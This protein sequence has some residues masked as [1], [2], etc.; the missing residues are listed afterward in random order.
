[1]T[2]EAGADYAGLD[3]SREAREQVVAAL[4]AS[5]GSIRHSEPYTHTVP[6]QPPLGRAHRAADLAAVVHGAWTSWPRPAIEAVERR[7]RAHPPRV[8]VAPLP[9]VAG[10]HP[11]VVH[12]APAVV[13]PPDPGLV[14]RRR[15]DLR[16]HRAARGRGLGARPR[17]ARHVVH[18]GAV[19]VRD[20]RLARGDA[21]AA[22]LLPDRRA[23]DGARHPLPVGRAHGDDGPRVHRRRPVRRRLRALGHP[24]ARRPADEQVAGHRH[25]PARRDRRATAPTRCASACWRCP[26]PRTCAT[27]PRR[28][29]R[30]RRWPT[31]SSTPRATCCCNVGAVDR[32]GAA[33]AR[34]SR[35]AGSSAACRRPRR[36]S[37]RN[38]DAF[39]FAKAA[40]GLYDFVYGELCDWYLEFI[41][42]REFDDD[43]SA[44][45]LHVLRETLAARPPGHPVRHRGAVVARARR[46]GPA[47]PA[48]QATRARRRR[49][50]T[51]TPRRAS[52]PSSPRSPRCAPGATRPASSPARCSRRAWTAST[53][54]PTLVARMAR[55]DLDG[56]RRADRRPCPFAGGMVEIRA[57]DARRPRRGGAQAR[58]RARAPAAARSRAPRP[59]SPTRAS[60]PRRREQ[61]VA[62]ERDKLERLRR[63]LEAL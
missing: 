24:G 8:A 49:C 56:R 10:E 13:G 35:T 5:R 52:A 48:Q 50:A 26:R 34:R 61:L 58:G 44:T 17:R 21:R 37:T 30:A 59:S 28:S 54:T 3:A 31:S 18:L 43:L 23:L 19:A 32:A 40:L 25:R 45:M 60:W 53:A 29:A 46:R 16:R 12:L 42:G 15:G 7:A 22:R 36:S 63:E 20:A 39:D 9:R 4:D 27:P 6:V 2:A 14:P 41:K 57:G 55:L 11:P 38:I 51:P 1:M 33:A 47:R 62:A